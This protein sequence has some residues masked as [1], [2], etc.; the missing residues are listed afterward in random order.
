MSHWI[1][2]EQNTTALTGDA[3]FLYKTVEIDNIVFKM[4]VLNLG[5][6]L[7]YLFINHIPLD[8][9]FK[10]ELFDL[11]LYRCYY[12]ITRMLC[13]CVPVPGAP[14]FFKVSALDLD[15][16]TLEWGPPHERNGRLSGYTFKYQTG[17][18][19][20][21]ALR[22]T[23]TTPPANKKD[24]QSNVECFHKLMQHH[25]IYLY[26][27]FNIFALKLFWKWFEWYGSSVIYH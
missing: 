11:K 25:N 3:N 14:S 24:A 5:Y 2:Q 15:S 22:L 23:V 19:T 6:V 17:E 16:L 8:K 4:C 18:R 10:P 1:I 13:V 27:E 9:V 26:Q 7:I 12:H 20:C 21:A